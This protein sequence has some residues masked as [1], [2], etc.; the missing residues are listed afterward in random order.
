VGAN[1]RHDQR[2]RTLFSQLSDW[3]SPLAGK[4]PAPSNRPFQAKLARAAITAPLLYSLRQTPPDSIGRVPSRD[5]VLH[6]ADGFPLPQSHS[7]L[8]SNVITTGA[9]MVS[10]S[11][12]HCWA[13]VSRTVCAF[14][15]RQVQD[16]KV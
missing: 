5:E 13:R 16:I 10:Q 14:N 1:L 12:G 3:P 11:L 15:I 4:L 2:S 8:A 6:G 9:P 7:R